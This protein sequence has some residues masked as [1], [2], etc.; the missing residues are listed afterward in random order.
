MTYAFYGWASPPPP[1]P[2]LTALA[3]VPGGTAVRDHMRVNGLA[4]AQREHDLFAEKEDHVYY[5]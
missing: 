1:S 2:T 3:D 4:A 5:S